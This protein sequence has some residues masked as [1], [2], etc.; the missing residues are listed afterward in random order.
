MRMNIVRKLR[1][2]TAYLLK[3]IIELKRLEQIHTRKHGTRP[4]WVVIKLI[5]AELSAGLL[6]SVTQKC[7]P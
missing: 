3:R 4:T 1:S 6:L 7:L 5:C 2:L